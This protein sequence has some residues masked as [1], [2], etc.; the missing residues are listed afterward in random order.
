MKKK[1]I[2]LSLAVVIL[3]VAVAGCG[4][5]TNKKSE[6]SNSELKSTEKDSSTTSSMMIEKDS[7]VY[8]A[9]V[10]ADSSSEIG[11]IWV[12]KLLPVDS[13]NKTPEI[14]KED[15]V[16]LTDGSNVFNGNNEKIS[17]DEIKL[18]DE[19]E[20]T[21]AANPVSTMSIPPQIPGE[22]VHKIILK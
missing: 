9:V 4:N 5:T 6:S 11:Q 21:V 20:I 19:L 13:T 22:A 16:L 2:V 10:K 7:V 12:E 15:V 3:F 8:T 18:G 14:F 17:L 1:S